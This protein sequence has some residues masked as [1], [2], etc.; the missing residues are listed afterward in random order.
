VNATIFH[1]AER[2]RIEE[3]LVDT[4]SVV[5]QLELALI[6]ANRHVTRAYAAELGFV[7]ATNLVFVERD[8]TVSLSLHE[9]ER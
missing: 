4:K 6:D 1:T 3:A 9:V 8:S 2:Q 7:D 5:S